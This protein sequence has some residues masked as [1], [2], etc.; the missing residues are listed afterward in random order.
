MVNGYS[1]SGIE[2]IP[3]SSQGEFMKEIEKALEREEVGVILVDRDYSSQMKGEI[4]RIKRK[5]VMPVLVEVLGRG[6][7]PE[8]D[9]KSTI[10]RI[11]GLKV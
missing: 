4:E 5:R 1:I 10:S 7:S 11:M 2:S 8:T 6:L 9:L 3:V